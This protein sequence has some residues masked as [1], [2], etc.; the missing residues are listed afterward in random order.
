[1]A[2]GRVVAHPRAARVPAVTSAAPRASAVR[3]GATI[4]SAR[5]KREAHPGQ[6]PHLRAGVTPARSGATFSNMAWIVRSVAGVG[7]I[8]AR[9]GNMAAERSVLD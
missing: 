2:R 9:D 3:G 5:R 7:L 1:V 8:P 6:R 4:G